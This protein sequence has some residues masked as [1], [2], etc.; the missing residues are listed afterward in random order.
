MLGVRV[1][2]KP[3]AAAVAPRRGVAGRARARQFHAEAQG[4]VGRDVVA[5]FVAQ[6]LAVGA[7][8][9]GLPL[10]QVDAQILVRMALAAPLGV[11]SVP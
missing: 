5:Q 4:G 11:G 6:H 2:E 9:H 3:Q 1:S 10:H 7:A 8:L